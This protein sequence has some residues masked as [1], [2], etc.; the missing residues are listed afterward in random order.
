MATFF[1]IVFDAA[2]AVRMMIT[3]YPWWEIVLWGLA[4]LIIAGYAWYAEDRDNRVHAADI[5]GL[6]GKLTFQ[7]G[8]MNA[9]IGLLG[10]DIT[11][12]L[13]EVLSV[14]PAQPPEIVAQAV[15]K[16]LSAS[17]EELRSQNEQANRE[18]QEIRT[19]LAKPES[20]ERKLEEINQRFQSLP[21]TYT[22][23]QAL[24]YAQQQARALQ[25]RSHRMRMISRALGAGGEKTPPEDDPKE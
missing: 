17:F 16:K 14:N 22:T 6:N 21:S 19:L 25:L 3:G 4:G 10:P 12:Q 11:K 13:T 23:P 8:Q 2:I 15:M 5:S 7:S 18:L 24:A 9:I 20:A 1:W